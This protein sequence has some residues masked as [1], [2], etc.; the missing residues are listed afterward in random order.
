MFNENLWTSDVG[1]L[2]EATKTKLENKLRNSQPRAREALERLVKEGKI[3]TDVVAPIGVNQRSEN[4]QP[5]ITFDSNGQLKMCMDENILERNQVNLDSSWFNLHENAVTQ[6]AEKFGV[7]GKYLK[8]LAKGEQWQRDLAAN[9]L[10]EHS[11]NTHRSRVL[12]RSVGNEVRGV[13]SDQYKRYDAKEIV[14]AFMQSVQ[15]QGGVLVDGLMTD[16][17]VFFETMKPYPIIVP[18]QKNGDVLLAF[19]AR[20][21]TSDFGNGALE[22]RSYLMQITCLNEMVRE[23]QLKKV[24]LGSRLPDNI[25]L[26][27]RT[28]NYDTKT[29]ASAIKDI[30]QQI[31]SN[32]N[33]DKQAYMIQRA[34]ESE[35]DFEKELKNLSRNKITQ[36]EAAGVQ[37]VIN[38][39][40][41]EDGLTGE[42]T[43]WKLVNGMTAYARDMENPERKRE[44]SE[45]AGG[46]M[47]RA[48]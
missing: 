25:Q 27:Q 32:E 12:V 40:D 39:S 7:P 36:E 43:L 42:G 4:P 45:I 1:A 30:T 9:I 15:E 38:K 48:K 20:L 11:Y 8:Q 37:K 14:T 24:H 23:T 17:R 10:N 28:Y 6:I 46:L 31:Y 33:I 21:A 19:G 44:I 35:V 34:S 29:M 16:T 41:P 18:T 13:L 47:E 26:S 3:Q 22:L 2:N 5:F